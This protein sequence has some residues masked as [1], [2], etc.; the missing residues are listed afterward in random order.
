ME[1]PEER[2][3]QQSSNFHYSQ[4]SPRTASDPPPL[5]GD[6][7]VVCGLRSVSKIPERCGNFI[8]SSTVKLRAFSRLQDNN[9]SQGTAQQIIY[10]GKSL[11]N[12]NFIITL[13]QEYL[14]KLFVS[15]FST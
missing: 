5:P 11:N 2:S 12:M 10:E 7:L 1:N 6:H 8:I 4:Q 13:L 9:V 15:Y 14:K 3:S